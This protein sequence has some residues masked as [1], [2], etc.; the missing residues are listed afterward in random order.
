M[1][2]I[3]TLVLS[4]IK[5]LLNSNSAQSYDTLYLDN[6]FINISLV[7]TLGQLDTYRG[8]GNHASQCKRAFFKFNLVKVC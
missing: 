8:Y 2:D 3:Q 6:L 5:S 4:L 7:N 1:A